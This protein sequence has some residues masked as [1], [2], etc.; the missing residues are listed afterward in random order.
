MVA[1]ALDEFVEAGAFTTEDEATILTEV[2]VHVVGGAALV[3]ADDP[4]VALLHGFQGA[5]DVDDLGD[6]GV[7]GGSGG[8]FGDDRVQGSGPAFGDDDAI[9]AGAIG[10]AEQGAEVVGVFD[11]VQHQKEAAAGLAMLGVEEVFEGEE[12]PLAEEG[13]DALM[14]VGFGVS[15]ELVAGFGGDADVGLAAEV[16][17]GFKARVAAGF[18]LAGDADVV[19]LANA[20]SDGLLDGVEAV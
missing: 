17:D 3:E 8:G 6:A 11:A 1:G 10:G 13:D 19:D 14:G 20:G 9:D 12:L 7:L 5:G 2:E 15:G 18:A 16:E 4:D